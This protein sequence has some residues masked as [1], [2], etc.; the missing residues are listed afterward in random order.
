LKFRA[1]KLHMIVSF[2]ITAHEAPVPTVPVTL[3]YLKAIY[4]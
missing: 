4:R 2:S 3:G 1:G